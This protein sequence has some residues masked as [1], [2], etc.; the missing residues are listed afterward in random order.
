MADDSEEDVF[1]VKRALEQSKVAHFFH[2][3]PDGSQALAYVKADGQYADR[4][5]FPFPNVLLCDL[6]MP[7]MDGFDVLRWL[8][9]HPRCK[10]IPTIMFSSSAIEADVLQSYVL[11]ANAYL[12]KP[13]S[14]DDLST[15]IQFLYQFWSRCQV[16]MAP[17]G[18][19]CS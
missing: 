12:E 2:A 6:K 8:R 11:G 15:T 18:D 13:S 19:R 3:V 16:P 14:L 17:P 1:F 10:V 4:Q 9:D 5:A 7:G